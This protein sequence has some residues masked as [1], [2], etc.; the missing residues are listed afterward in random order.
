MMISRKLLAFAA[1][2][3]VP[4]VAYAAPAA[5]AATPA[6]PVELV[7]DVKLDKVT[8]VNGQTRHELVAPTTVLPGDHLIF[9]TRYRN[10]G[11]IPV[12]NFVVTNP[13]PSAVAA[14]AESAAALTVS[15]DGGKTWGA[16][17]TQS[18]GDGKGGRRRAQAGDV[19]HIR[20]IIPAIQPG[21]SGALTYH[22]TVR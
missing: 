17:A 5:P 22:A 15:V 13:L 18:V 21:A 2:V 10:T 1:L 11:R 7:G 19:T 3:A 6:S 9:T 14:T 16:L 12:T 8:V 20:W 4:A